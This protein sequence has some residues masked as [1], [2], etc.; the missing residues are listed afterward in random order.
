MIIPLDDLVNRYGQDLISHCGA[1]LEGCYYGGKLYGIP[2]AYTSGEGYAYMVRDD[3]LKKYGV[4]VDE[5][6][7][8]TLADVEALFEKVKAGEGPNF[9]CTHTLEHR[10]VALKQLLY[11]L[12]QGDGILCGGRADAQP[13]LHRPYHN[14]PV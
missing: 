7:T 2:P 1:L 9:Y 14:K 11:R 13:Q 4:T 5:N 10:T 3:M 6:K 8:Y 12:R